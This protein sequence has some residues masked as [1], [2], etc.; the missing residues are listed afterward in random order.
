MKVQITENKDVSVES[1]NKVYL[2]TYVL[3]KL[4]LHFVHRYARIL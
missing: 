2:F 3:Y 1:E 4:G